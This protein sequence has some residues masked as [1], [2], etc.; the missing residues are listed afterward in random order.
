[1]W[2]PLKELGKARE[3]EAQWAAKLAIFKGVRSI[4]SRPM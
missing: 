3:K 2:F 1:M 4:S